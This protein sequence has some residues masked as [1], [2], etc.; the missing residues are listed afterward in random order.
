MMD[1]LRR[2]APQV[3][4]DDNS[5]Y[6]LGLFVQNDHGV[7]VLHHGGNTLGFTSDLFVLPEHELGVIVLTNA[8][9]ANSFRRAVRRRFL[10]ILFDGK[11]TAKPELLASEAR[12][13]RALDET[14][15]L[16]KPT[17]DAGWMEKLVGKY[18]NA[19]LGDLE[20]R[21]Q[22]AGFVLDVGEWKSPATEEVDLDKT[23]KLILTGAPFAGFDM[24]PVVENGVPT[25]VLDAGQVKYVFAPVS[26]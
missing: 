24:V 21:K 25:L 23:E 15:A 17:P 13:R 16:I 4:I 1:L 19:D 12:A 18:R 9:G 8:G 2:R 14:I 11:E 10:E 22:G 7:Q 20:V 6:G 26:K 3:K 5:S